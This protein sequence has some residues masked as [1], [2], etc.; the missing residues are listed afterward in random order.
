[1]KRS[2]ALRT[3][4]G[5]L[6]TRG[7]AFVAAGFTAIGCAV[8]LGQPALTR[9]GVLMAVIPVLGA[10]VVS[11]HRYRLA[12][13]RTVAPQLVQVGQPVHVELSL[14]NEGSRAQG[15]L[16]LEEQ[17]PYALGSRPRFVLDPQPD[18]RHRV[19]YTVS[20][21]LRGR[22]ELGP[23]SVR[24]TDPFGMVELGRSFQTTSA[25]TVTPR[26]VPL[27][28]VSFGGVW[29]GSGDNR[30]RA[31]S[32]GSAEDV[33]VREYRRGDDLRRVHWRSSARVGE[34]MVRREEQPWQSRATLVLDNRASAHR[35]VGAAS[36]LEAA[37]TAAA[38]IAVHL[39]RRG[40]LVRLVT[41]SGDSPAAL[42]HARDDESNTGA[43]LEALAVLAASPQVS[44]DA[45]WVA[46]GGHGGLLIAILGAIGD[47]DTIPLRR[48]R[49]ASPTALALTLDVT[50][51]SP[52]GSPALDPTSLLTPQGWR[53]SRWGPGEPL[54]TPWR[55]LGQSSRSAVTA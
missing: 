9:V 22:F 3:A 4:L 55:G 15:V 2:H 48:I 40:F 6:T 31:S 29:S 18:R 20:S 11:R 16:L 51:W 13:V 8:V 33:T 26:I 14:G 21:E 41:A 46:D 49:S 12:L 5:S 32:T 44:L 38:S 10:I 39:S 28:P 42:W 34:L 19:T 17:L 50:R 23:L 54:E 7:R 47:T 53:V 1:M 35:G 43:L 37:V 36:S 24:Q 27:P 45:G 30:P 25:M 52:T